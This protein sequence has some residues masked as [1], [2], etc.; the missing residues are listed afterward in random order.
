MKAPPGVIS[1]PTVPAARGSL[2]LIG[3]CLLVPFALY[4]GTAQSIVAIWNSS[5]TFAHGYAILPISLWLVWRRREVFSRMA[6]AP[7]WPALVPL[8]LCGAAWLLASS[9]EVQVLRQY[10]FVAMIPLSA[11]ALLGPRLAGALAFPLLF[12]LFAVPFGEIFVN[13]LIGFTAD[14][15]VA[16]VRA[17][18]IPVLRNGARFELPSGSWSVVEACSGIRYLISS[19]TLGCLYAYLTYRSP[20]R[21]AAFIALSV[22]VPI[23]ANGLRAFMIVM[24]GHLSGMKLATG[25][26]HL[27]YGWL[28]FGLVMFIMFWI[29]GYWRDDA[30][31]PPARAVVAPAQVPAPGR[32]VTMA[33]A[34][35][36]LAAAW[37][38]YGYYIDQANFNPDPVKFQRVRIGWAPAP[39]FTNW[40]PRYLEPDAGFSGAWQ[41]RGLAPVGMT[42]LYYRNQNEG[43]KLV[44]SIN[45]LADPKDAWH[46]LESSARSEQ[47]A[48]RTLALRETTLQREGGALLVWQWLWTGGEYTASTYMGKLLQARSKLLVHGD[49]GAALMVYAPLTDK[50]EAARAAM[51]A[52]LDDHLEPIGLALDTAR[53]AQALR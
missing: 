1:I 10:A 2:L 51:R 45:R 8:A 18:G 28:F 14:F 49:D 22:V 29:G 11:L 37:P 36:A 35:L 42:I 26:D 48:G 50:P 38:A 15:T 9:A 44:T 16:A 13:P 43:H 17:V 7:W 21:R 24:I 46:E 6:P 19:V 30:V 31:E 5:E 20:L 23:I 52:F 40:T 12:L 34:V 32:V 4:L 41:A 39:G 47:V 25:V 3:L 27:I 33:A 53:Q